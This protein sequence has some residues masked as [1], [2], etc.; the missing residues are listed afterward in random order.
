MAE[1]IFDLLPITEQRI[2]LEAQSVAENGGGTGI[3][4]GGPVDVAD[5]EAVVLELTIGTLASTVTGGTVTLTPLE[6]SLANGGDLAPVNS[7]T[8]VYTYSAGTKKAVL[9][10]RYLGGANGKLRYVAIQVTDA[11]TGS[12]G[13]GASTCIV[14][15]NV[16]TG[17]LRYAGQQ[18]TAGSAPQTPGGALSN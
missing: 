16:L 8:V 10:Y 14:A 2:S 17:G 1:R 18:P 12:G 9:R 11:L 4:P 13:A 15:G 7:D 6:G 5:R 3:Y